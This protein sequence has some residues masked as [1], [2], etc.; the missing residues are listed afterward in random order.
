MEKRKITVSAM[1]ETQT[2]GETMRVE[3]VPNKSSW[4]ES[5]TLSVP[6]M[7]EA[8]DVRITGKAE[9][10][11]REYDPM[12]NEWTETITEYPL[13]EVQLPVQINESDEY[14]LRYAQVKLEHFA[15]DNIAVTIASSEETNKGHIWQVYPKI[16]ITKIE[17]TLVVTGI[18]IRR[19]DGEDPITVTLPGITMFSSDEHPLNVSHSIRVIFSDSLILFSDVHPSNAEDSILVTL[20]GITIFSSDVHPANA[21][22]SILVTLSGISTLTIS[23]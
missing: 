8:A 9:F 7:S 22:Y 2:A 18:S 20:S 5:G 11:H 15:G 1:A 6:R 10:M 4:I 3:L 16:T 12:T 21:E 23:D 14:I 17:G 19:K 13:N